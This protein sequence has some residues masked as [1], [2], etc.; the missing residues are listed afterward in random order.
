[1]AKTMKNDQRQHLKSRKVG[2][3]KTRNNP[4]KAKNNNRKA[5]CKSLQTVIVTPTVMNIN[6]AITAAAV[7]TVSNYTMTTVMT[8]EGNPVDP[9]SFD[10]DIGLPQ[11]HGSKMITNNYWGDVGSGVDDIIEWG[12]NMEN[13]SGCAS[14]GAC[15]GNITPS[16]YL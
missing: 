15:R 1:M 10:N 9:S 13:Y 6:A 8:S 12:L 3:T 14:Y 4:I 5:F 2:K 11:E 16:N 7:M